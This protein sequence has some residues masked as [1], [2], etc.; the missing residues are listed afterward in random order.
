MFLD[1]LEIFVQAGRGG[2]GCT[3][4]RR[5][6]YVEFGGPDGGDGG[7]G[8]EIIV[9]VRPEFNTLLPLRT[10]KHY[11]AGKGRNGKG[12]NRTG[13]RG[14][15]LILEV[16]TGT[17]I[18]ERETGVL[19]GDLTHAVDEVVVAHGGR[20]GKG[21]KH[22]AS[23][24][25]RAPRFSQPGEDGEGLW[26]KLELKIMADVGLVGFPNAGK[27]TLISRISAARPKVA[28]YPFTTLQP[29]L[30]V[31]AAGQFDS[32]VV[33]DIPG[34]IE[35]AHE[36]A[37]LGLRFLRHIERTSVLLLLIDPADPARDV[38]TCYRVLCYELNSF[39]A[40]LARKKIIIAFTKADTPPTDPEQL[41]ALQAALTTQEI[42][43]HTISAVR[44]D[45]IKELIHD[46]Y[47]VVRA[48][49]SKQ[50]IAV[51]P[52][53]VNEEETGNAVDPLDE[54]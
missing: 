23:A 51:D 32:F 19:I 20:G 22:F 12:S 21:N 35:G 42:S 1:E 47:A 28:D 30:G 36:G 54:I 4:F 43:Y 11:R 50:P 25:N 9:R 31:V 2:S 13:A 6:K 29:N 41:A 40:T 39:S 26:I 53:D 45:G 37:G 8:G 27:S 34:I 5:E 10:R 24:T 44:G 16:P 3:S 33:A 7:D 48:E 49:K 46:L 14:E 15:T 52:E 38:E 18:R 17:L